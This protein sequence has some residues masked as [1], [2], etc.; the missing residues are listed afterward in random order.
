[1][2]PRR[3]VKLS[4]VRASKQKWLWTGRIPLGALTDLSGD[5]AQAKSRIVWDLAARLSSGRPMPGEH[6][7]HPPAGVVL[8]QTE[9]DVGAT[10]MPT[11]R[12]MGADL[13]RI[14]A[15]DPSRS[16]GNPLTLPDEIEHVRVAV[17]QV[18]AKLVVV[19]NASSIFRCNFNDNRSVR[20]VLRPLAD[21][22]ATLQLAVVIV[23]HLRKASSK[24]TLHSGAGSIAWSATA[25]SG[26]FATSDPTTSDQ[27]KHLLVQTKSN[28]VGAKTI[29]YQTVKIANCVGIQWGS[30]LAVTARDLDGGADVEHTKLADAVEVLYSIL[31]NGPMSVSD[32]RYR[33]REAG[34]SFRTLE[35]AKVVLGVRSER[36][37]VSSTFSYWVWTLPNEE[38]PLLAHLRTKH[39]PSETLSP[40]RDRPLNQIAPRLIDSDLSGG[41]GGAAGQS[42]RDA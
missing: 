32:I 13:E 4:K 22:A 10:V 27:Y 1:M 20:E 21:L 41:A 29:A 40:A 17:N 16:R 35:R 38:S 14:L 28:L 36:R 42:L 12:E 9:D 37:R 8:V 2:K 6:S 34:V 23:R 26:L 25:R 39:S 3:F 31:L 19:D 33:A 5:P 24:S 18:Q 15:H 11:L 7:P 30:E